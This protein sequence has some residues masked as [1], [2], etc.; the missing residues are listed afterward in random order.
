[1]FHTQ[2]AKEE[3]VFSKPELFAFIKNILCKDFIGE[4]NSYVELVEM[5]KK[6]KLK[7][8]NEQR[9]NFSFMNSFKGKDIIKDKEIFL[10]EISPDF[11]TSKKGK[12][13]KNLLHIN[14]FKMYMNHENKNN[15]Y[16]INLLIIEQK[17]VDSFLRIMSQ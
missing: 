3:K 14:P 1:M 10:I 2:I 8:I 9:N 6:T 17:Y 13:I 15:N 16:Y 12:K 11:S 4:I 5:S 7:L